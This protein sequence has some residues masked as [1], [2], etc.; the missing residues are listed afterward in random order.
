MEFEGK[1]GEGVGKERNWECEGNE[2][3]RIGKDWNGMG[4]KEKAKKEMLIGWDWRGKVKTEGK[5]MRGKGCSGT[6]PEA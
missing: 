6:L 5:G 4:R 2:R 3:G 1:E